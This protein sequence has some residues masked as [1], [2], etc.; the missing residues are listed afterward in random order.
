MTAIR[1]WASLALVISFA[2]V[3]GS[4]L[5]EARDA[6]CAAHQKNERARVAFSHG[7]PPLNGDKLAVTVVEVN[8][9]P[10]ESSPRH[11]HPCPVTGYV[12]EGTLRTQV[13]GKSEEIYNAGESFYEAPN[14]VHL[15]SANA[16]DRLPLKL[17]AYFVCD[18][19]TPL[20]L[21]VPEAKTSGGK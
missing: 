2:A 3:A 17:L 14:G 11:S 13:Q 4:H 18:H 19:D 1:M 12:V 5:V 8:Y 10:G 6:T 7:L 21:A 20:S 9:G 15:I 16:S